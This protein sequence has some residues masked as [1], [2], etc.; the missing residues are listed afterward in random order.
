MAFNSIENPSLAREQPHNP[1]ITVSDTHAFLSL[2]WRPRENNIGCLFFGRI[3]WVNLKMKDHWPKFFHFKK[4]RPTNSQL[5]D[6]V[7][8]EV[9][10][11]ENGADQHIMK[12]WKMEK[13]DIL[14]E[15]TQFSV[16]Y[17][18]RKHCSFLSGQTFLFMIPDP[19]ISL[20]T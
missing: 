20:V 7:R 8:L 17:E 6:D 15:P 12:E 4:E 19:R 13:Q 2:V 18:S 9:M 14:E 10:Q 5:S 16:L 1:V 3:L 11:E